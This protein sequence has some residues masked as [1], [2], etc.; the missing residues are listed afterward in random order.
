LRAD[1][2]AGGIRRGG[3]LGLGAGADAGLLDFGVEVVWR[4]G[5]LDCAGVACRV[6]CWDGVVWRDV[7]CEE[8]GFSE[9]KRSGCGVVFFRRAGLTYA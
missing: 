9:E 7:G 4:K 1:D 3:T 6:A 5:L 2:E 8:M